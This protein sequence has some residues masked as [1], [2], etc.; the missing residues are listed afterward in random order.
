MNID[1]ILSSYQSQLLTT[2]KTVCPWHERPCDGK[3]QY[4]LIN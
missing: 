3:N 4:V 1:D 2:H